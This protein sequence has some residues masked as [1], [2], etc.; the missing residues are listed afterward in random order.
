[1]RVLLVV[2]AS[3]SSF[4]RRKRLVIEHALRADHVLEVAETSERGHAVKLARDAAAE[5]IE[6]VAVLAGDGTI[7]EAAQGLA[8][9]ATAL[10]PLPGGS[11]NVFARTIGV[12][13]DVVDATAQLLESLEI[14]SWRRIGLGVANGRHFLFHC[15]I[16][17]DAAVVEQVERRH[18]LKR[19]VAHPLFAATMVGTWLRR[20]DHSRARF[21]VELPGEEPLEDGIF[22]I[23]SNT[24]P[25][26]YFGSRAIVVSPDTTLDTR[27]GLTVL[28][29]RHLPT[30]LALVASALATGRMLRRNPTVAHRLDLDR[31]S[32]IGD[33]PFPWQVDGDF[34]GETERL[35]IAFRPEALMLVMPTRDPAF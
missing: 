6:A 28:R 22:A 26:A 18:P 24:S 20:Y 29:T 12:S 5:G 3:A 9:T 10:A 33:G 7:N 19:Y 16:G 21:R 17:L 2:N 8:G 30:L 25:Y 13:R 23:V 11:T 4:T 15:G 1:M 14:G 35:D 34:L 31:I 27:L 32:V